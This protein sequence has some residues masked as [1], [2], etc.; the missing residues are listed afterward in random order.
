MAKVGR[1]CYCV[2]HLYSIPLNSLGL[3]LEELRER[4]RVVDIF[5]KFL[6]DLPWRSDRPGRNKS[7]TEQIS[8]IHI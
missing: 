6:G 2:K 4:V 1:S 5:N 7:E 3:S 8:H